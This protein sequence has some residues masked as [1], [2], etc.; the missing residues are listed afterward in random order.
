MPEISALCTAEEMSEKFGDRMSA[1]RLLELAEAQLVPHYEL[2]GEILF[3]ITE[4]K[5]W[6]EKRLLLHVPGCPIPQSISLTKMV[7]EEEFMEPPNVLGGAKEFLVSLP[8]GA[9]AHVLFSGVYF[10]C[11]SDEVVYVGQSVSVAN[12]VVQHIGLKEY[13]RAYCLR[14][15]RSDLD[16]VEG[17]FIRLLKPKYNHDKNGTLR[18][19]MEMKLPKDSVGLDAL[20]ACGK[21]ITDGWG[22]LDFTRLKAQK[23]QEREEERAIRLLN[24]SSI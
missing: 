19:P 12:R 24:Q 17:E 11:Q 6:V 15:P 8:I 20:E 3:A 21:D 16:F 22:G 5:R 1:E 14:V 13:D 2:E 9:L 4:T 18:G 7:S 23:A 10:L